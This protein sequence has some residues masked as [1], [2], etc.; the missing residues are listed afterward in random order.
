YDDTSPN[1]GVRLAIMDAG[2]YFTS[3]ANDFS[4]PRPAIVMVFEG[5]HR[6]IREKESYDDLI[7]LDHYR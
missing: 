1:K 2:A 7:R 6:L 5:G 4:L 3:F